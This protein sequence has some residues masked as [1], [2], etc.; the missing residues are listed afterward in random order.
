[1]SLFSWLYTIYRYILRSATC[2]GTTIW[3]IQDSDFSPCPHSEK[4][5]LHSLSAEL[6]DELNEAWT[7]INNRI[8]R[9]REPIPVFS[10]FNNYI[11]LSV[12]APHPFRKIEWLNEAKKIIGG[13]STLKSQVSKIWPTSNPNPSFMNS[14]LLKAGDLVCIAGAKKKKELPTRTLRH[15]VHHILWRPWS[16]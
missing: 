13:K 4:S 15:G 8:F 6:W 14:G 11:D 2:H 7:S 3:A 10:G 9:K 1:M 12:L 16:K 5:T